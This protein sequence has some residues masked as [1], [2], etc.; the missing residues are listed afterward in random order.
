M[1]K[2]IYKIKIGEQIYY[3]GAGLQLYSNR[4]MAFPITFNEHLEVMEK[5]GVE[6]VAYSE[7]YDPSIHV[8]A[9]ILFKA[10]ERR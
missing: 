1:D 10:M 8:F 6:A 4:E 2:K 7:E 3:I 9:D 5:I